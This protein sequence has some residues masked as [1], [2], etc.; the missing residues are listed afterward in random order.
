MGIVTQLALCASTL[1]LNPIEDVVFDR[2][3]LVEV[4]HYYDDKGRHV[5]DQVIFYDWSATTGRYQVRDWRMLKRRAQIPRRNWR[6]GHY[7]SIWHDP[8][9]EDVM[10]RIHAINMHETWT[11]YDPEIIERD[12][13]PKEKRRLLTKLRSNAKKR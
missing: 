11:Q 2:V 3:D 8:L 6:L 1:S 12:H 5:L 13:L 7:M 10:R 4:N 9:G